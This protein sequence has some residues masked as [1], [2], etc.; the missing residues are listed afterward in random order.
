M[1]TEESN[2]DGGVDF[3]STGDETLFEGTTAS[4]RNF[5]EDNKKFLTSYTTDN[6]KCK[7]DNGWYSSSR[8]KPNQTNDD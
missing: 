8:R 7:Y 2:R 3:I 1:V 5:T 4:S 6:A